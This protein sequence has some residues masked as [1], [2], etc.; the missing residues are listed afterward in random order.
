MQVDVPQ[1]SFRFIFTLIPNSTFLCSPRPCRLAYLSG[2]SFAAEVAKENPT[3]VTI[4]CKDD[5]VAQRVQALLS[6]NRFRCYR[7]HDVA[8]VGTLSRASRVLLNRKEW[9]H[10]CPW[11]SFGVLHAP[12][13]RVSRPQWACALEALALPSTLFSVCSELGGALKNVLAIACGISDG[14]GFGR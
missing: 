7:T 6:T 9:H 10:L 2:P 3:A 14:L 13:V 4:A 12:H 1:P 11:P 8:G 5:A